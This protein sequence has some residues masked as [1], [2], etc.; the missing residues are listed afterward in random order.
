[1]FDRN[2]PDKSTFGIDHGNV[3]I[4]IFYRQQSRP[5]GVFVGRNFNRRFAY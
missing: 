3:R 2:C 5:L 1:M 4:V